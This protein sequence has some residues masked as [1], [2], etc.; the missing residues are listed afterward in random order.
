M[1][2]VSSWFLL[3]LGFQFLLMAKTSKTTASPPTTKTAKTIKQVEVEAFIQRSM[4][5]INATASIRPQ[6]ERRLNWR[7][8]G[9]V[10]SLQ[11]T[12]YS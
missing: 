11:F 5:K 12:V 7:G 10:H 6:S 4:L 3:V 8:M 9:V 2:V 1:E